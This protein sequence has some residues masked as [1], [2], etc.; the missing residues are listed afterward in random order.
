MFIKFGAAAVVY[1][2][3]P[4]PYYHC[5]VTLEPGTARWP[6]DHFMVGHLQAV[7]KGVSLLIGN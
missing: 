4:L 1:K 2:Q 7:C 5:Q 6:A 3:L